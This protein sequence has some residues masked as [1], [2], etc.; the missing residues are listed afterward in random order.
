M[1]GIK[2]PSPQ[3]IWRFSSAHLRKVISK[4][5]WS[6]I[7]YMKEILEVL[8]HRERAESIVSWSG[9]HLKYNAIFFYARAGES[10]SCQFFAASSERS[11]TFF[12]PRVQWKLWKV[13]LNYP[14]D[15]C[16]ECG[17]DFERT[18][19]NWLMLQHEGIIAQNRCSK[20]KEKYV[21]EIKHT[22]KQR[23]A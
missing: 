1:V 8:D 4:T 7:Q 10:A 12:T 2:P 16:G 6:V 19:G 9:L 18:A 17:T 5:K 21:I 13:H 15:T 3:Q 23:I 22:I 11:A 20:L 14:I